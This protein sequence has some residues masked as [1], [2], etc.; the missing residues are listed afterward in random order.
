[1]NDS[2]LQALIIHATSAATTR[3]L[4]GRRMLGM[5]MDVKR[6]QRVRAM[7]TQ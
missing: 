6:R 3:A 4:R 7:L 1:M 2:E 5:T